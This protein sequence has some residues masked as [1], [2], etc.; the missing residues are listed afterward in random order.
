MRSRNLL[1]LLFILLAPAF[2]AGCGVVL[3]EPPKQL[4]TA[5]K[6]DY[7]LMEPTRLEEGHIFMRRSAELASGAGGSTMDSET[8]RNQDLLLMDAPPRENRL[9]ALP[10]HKWQDIKQAR[11]NIHVENKPFQDL[12]E[13]V[14]DR[15]E[16][17][18]GP[19][20]VQWKLTRENRDLLNERFSLN[21]ETT[22]DRF[23]SSVAAFVLNHRG[24]ELNF[25]LFERERVLVISDVFPT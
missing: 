17:R 2:V 13:D 21:T 1:N 4:A 14:V 15:V 12:I 23:I 3:P 7:F 24:L 6:A 18:V 10:P 19:W 11:V 22:F 5:P 25:E 9:S 16:P 8:L 20:R